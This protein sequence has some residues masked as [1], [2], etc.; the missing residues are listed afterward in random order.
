[1]SGDFGFVTMAH[2]AASLR[3]ARA[4]ART[5]RRHE[6]GAPLALLAVRAARAG[7][8]EFD[9]VVAVAEPEPFAPPYRFFNKLLALGR[10]AP[11]ARSFFLDDD[12]LVL[13]PLR[14]T[15]EERCAGL[16]FALACDRR[17]ADAPFAG[18]NHV[19]PGAVAAECG[20][21]TVMDPYGGGHLYFERPACERYFRE[22]IDLALHEPERFR[23][24]TRDGFLGDEPALAIVANRHRL[25][26]PAL[27]SWIDPLDRARAEATELDLERGRYRFPARD[28]GADGTTRLLHFC[29]DGKAA[30]T[31]ERALAR[32]LGEPEPRPRW[33]ALFG[34]SGVGRTR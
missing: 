12:V 15:I 26:M 3:R 28:R 7:A 34:R 20:V 32:L 6:P 24:L 10:H 23:R 16:P 29:A 11:Y 4:L 5:L 25:P 14:A 22:A 2:D 27:D 13:G 18:A 8:R 1:M 19:D 33:R 17:P 30:S 9:Q 31:Y 21:A